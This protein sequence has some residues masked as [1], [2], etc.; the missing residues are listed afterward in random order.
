METQF[1]ESPGIALI[2]IPVALF[3]RFDEENI[4]VVSPWSAIQLTSTSPSRFGN[5]VDPEYVN[6]D[7]DE[8]IDTSNNP[9][10]PV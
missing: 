3:M 1:E 8:S 7:K 5:A 2:V 4:V 10:L 9:A 6:F